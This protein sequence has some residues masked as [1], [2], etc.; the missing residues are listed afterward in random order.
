MR[1]PVRVIYVQRHL[2]KN[3]RVSATFSRGYWVKLLIIAPVSPENR[4][5]DV[6]FIQIFV[7]QIHYCFFFF[8]YVISSLFQVGLI[9]ISFTFREC[10]NVC[11]VS[12]L[13]TVIYSQIIFACY[14]SFRI[15]S[16]LEFA[17]VW[18][19]MLKVKFS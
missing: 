4:S 3:N 5:Y 7:P 18:E 10:S 11:A 12:F 15:T 16:L 14:V 6:K 8:I 1:S 9:F 2:T 19:V 17:A 13:F